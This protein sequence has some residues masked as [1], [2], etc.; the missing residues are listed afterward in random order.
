[1]SLDTSFD[2]LVYVGIATVGAAAWWFLFYA[3]GPQVSF[4]QL[5]SYFRVLLA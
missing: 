1:M 4:Y 5:V 3:D 2:F